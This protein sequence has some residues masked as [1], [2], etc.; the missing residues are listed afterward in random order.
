MFILEWY[1]ASDHIA[2]QDGDTST[3]RHRDRI[4]ALCRGGMGRGVK[5]AQKSSYSPLSKCLRI[6]TPDEAGT[7]NTLTDTTGR[8]RYLTGIPRNRRREPKAGT[9]QVVRCNEHDNDDGRDQMATQMDKVVKTTGG[10]TGGTTGRRIGGRKEGR[11][12]R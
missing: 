7:E 3:S 11:R 10:T 6:G 2:A 4:K 8:P 12:V 5:G 1:D 9:E